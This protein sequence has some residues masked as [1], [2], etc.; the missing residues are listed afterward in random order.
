MPENLPAETP[1]KVAKIFRVAT[2]ADAPA[3]QAIYAPFCGAE[4]PV[5]FELAPPSVEDMRGRLEE[6]LKTMP[7]LIVQDIDGHILGYAYASLHMQRPAYRW[8]V[9][10]SIYM[11][12]DSRGQGLGKEL[13]K[14]LF[15]VLKAMGFC[16]AYGG[17]TL[18]NDA[19]VALHKSLGFVEVGVYERVGYKAKKWH[20]VGWYHLALQIHPEEPAEPLGFAEFQTQNFNADL[21][22]LLV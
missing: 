19:S 6:T 14:R 3:V 9:N 12:P 22:D 11:H 5:S 16:N 4:C 1:V 8:S 20:D 13:Y 2:Y 17:I 18:P 10:V 7:W 15:A 21:L